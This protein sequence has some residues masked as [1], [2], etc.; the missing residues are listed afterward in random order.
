[1]RVHGP[2][3]SFVTGKVAPEPRFLAHTL[4]CPSCGHVEGSVNMIF[5]ASNPFSQGSDSAASESWR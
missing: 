1:M 3:C 4:R 2:A 5:V